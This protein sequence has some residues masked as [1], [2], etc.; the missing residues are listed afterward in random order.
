MARTFVALATALAIMLPVSA[1]S[2]Q[3]ADL[4]LLESR[5]NCAIEQS[6]HGGPQPAALGETV[7]VQ[8]ATE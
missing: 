6:R 1:A 2:A 7:T 3:D 4:P 5:Y 8:L